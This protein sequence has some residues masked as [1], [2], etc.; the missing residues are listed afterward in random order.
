MNSGGRRPGGRTGESAYQSVR[1]RIKQAIPGI[2]RP[3]TPDEQPHQAAHVKNAQQ[4]KEEDHLE[5]SAQ[6]E[7]NLQSI[8]N[9]EPHQ[10]RSD[11]PT[12]GK[13]EEGPNVEVHPIAANKRTAHRGRRN[14]V[15]SG[16]THHQQWRNGAAVIDICQEEGR[17]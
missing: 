6:L 10:K 7:P 8:M 12:P 15:S 9:E 1:R 2:G 14:R 11:A 16:T 3:S 5:E 4:S 13:E 17:D